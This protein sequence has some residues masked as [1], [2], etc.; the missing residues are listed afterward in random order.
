VPRLSPFRGLV[1][2]PAV[3]GPLERVTAPPYDVISAERRAEYLREPLNVV[4]LDLAEGSEDPA[5]PASRY[6]RA[7]DLLA[8]WERRGILRR[9]LAPMVYVY[10]MT[11]PTSPG[12][13]GPVTIRG[14]ICAMELEDWGGS[15]LPHERVMDGPVRDR[16]ALLRATHTHLSPVYGTVTGPDPQLGELVRS[17]AD[18]APGFETVDEQGV[19]H[20]MWAVPGE[21]AELSHLADDPL[22]I[23]DGHHRYT[24]ALSYRDERRRSDG[25]GPWDSMLTLVVDATAERLEVAPFH[26][27]Q[28]TG[29][30][31]APSGEPKPGLD[32]TIASLDDDDVTIGIGRLD[33]HGEVLYERR[34][35][36]GEPPTVRALHAEV[37]DGLGASASVRYEPDAAEAEAALR[38]AEAVAVYL[39]PPTTPERIRTVVD[40][41]E[42]LPE[43]STYFWP[44]PRTGIVMMPLDPPLDGPADRAAQAS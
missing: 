11:A 2:D 19:R 35:L 41:G 44:K 22:L 4:H 34:R 15:V 18:D 21:A 3:A 5:D 40:R 9:A 43:K 37:L 16:L 39:L 1:Y 20:R 36:P 7:G 13:T 23:A 24:T 28:L 17:A 27:V 12:A 38:R 33:A 42:R 14:V 25:A 32:E 26:R 29:S 31:P 30:V 6:A 10:E 8:D